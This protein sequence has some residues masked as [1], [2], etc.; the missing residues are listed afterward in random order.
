[1]SQFALRWILMVDA[2]S[3]AIPGGKKPEQVADT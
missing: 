1:M 3:C 2:V